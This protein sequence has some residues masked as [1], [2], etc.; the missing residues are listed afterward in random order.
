[1]K[2]TPEALQ[3]SQ[4][5]SASTR[6]ERL[7]SRDIGEANQRSGKSE[8]KAA[9]RA[10]GPKL[11]SSVSPDLRTLT[12]HVPLK[13][14]KRGGRTLVVGPDDLVSLPRCARIDNTLVRAL[15]RAFRWQKLLEGSTYASIAELA[16]AE[17]I[18]DSYVSRL[19]RLTLLAPDIVEA[20]LDGRRSLG[21]QIETLLKPMP[22]EWEKQKATLG[23]LP[24][25]H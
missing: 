1:V 23:V 8:P 22:V 25:G 24:Q 3:A 5:G 21:L 6:P 2:R 9:K 10:V 4:K 17:Q 16:R 19:L 18:N 12:V 11:R 13:L 7:R 14:H 20:I 15:A